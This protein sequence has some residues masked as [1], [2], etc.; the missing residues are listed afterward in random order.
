MPSQVPG[1]VGKH[2]HAHVRR[3]TS[4]REASCMA[5]YRGLTGKDVAQSGHVNIVV[6]GVVKAR[7]SRGDF[8]GEIAL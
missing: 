3:H 1:A 6:D 5:V 7:R 2:V 8:I 4:T